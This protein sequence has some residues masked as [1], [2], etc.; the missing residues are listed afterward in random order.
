MNEK[1]ESRFPE[2]PRI[3]FLGT[4][5]FAVSSLKVLVREGHYIHT[6]ITQPDRPKG[7]GRKVLPSP[8]KQIALD[9][10]IRVLQPENISTPE[11]YEEIRQ[12]E[13]DVFIVVAFGLI[14]KKEFLDI[15]KWGAINIHASLLPGYRGAAPINCAILNN[16]SKTGLTAMRMD[17][18]LDTGPILF[19]EEL[20]ILAD[21]TAGSLHNRL[22]Q[23][24]GKFLIKTLNDLSKGLLNDI[25]QDD[26]GSSYAP[27]INRK[28]SFIKWDQPAQSICLLIRAL[29]PWPGAYTMLGK[30][31]IKLFS[32]GISDDTMTDGIP[33]RIVGCSDGAL[34]VETGKGIIRIGELQVSGKKRL[35]VN[36]FLRGFSLEAKTILG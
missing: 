32:A 27:K 29:D 24:S 34:A 21:E 4:P 36:D 16:E 11:F 23:M 3:V 17:D 33:G 13:P 14:L 25:P 22:A 18:G 10:G 15:P 20:P 7:R 9:C 6:V 35:P 12:T 2:L 1:T 28:M 31:E 30:K 5:D 19:Q 26:A 8:V